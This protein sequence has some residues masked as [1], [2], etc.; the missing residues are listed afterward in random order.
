MKTY[1]KKV[2]ELEEKFDFLEKNLDRE[3][4][5]REIRRH[6]TK[7][8]TQMLKELLEKMNEVDAQKNEIVKI[9]KK[10]CMGKPTTFESGYIHHEVRHQG[11]RPKETGER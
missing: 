11:T 2:K 10:R 3:S 9:R 8:Y 5:D 6:H 4:N 7:E 1:S